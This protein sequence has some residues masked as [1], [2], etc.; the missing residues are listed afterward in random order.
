MEETLVKLNE[1]QF[2]L[3]QEINDPNSSYY[4]VRHL[5][6]PE[7]LYELT[8]VAEWTDRPLPWKDGNWSNCLTIENDGTKFTCDLS[9]KDN[10]GMRDVLM[11][12][13]YYY[14][15][16]NLI[17]HKQEYPALLQKLLEAEL[18]LLTADAREPQRKIVQE[19]KKSQPKK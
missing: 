7:Q 3:V 18:L 1:K 12:L 8:P 14:E 15:M 11:F 4:R 6:G 5:I 9:N 17:L 2:E 13:Y 19:I 10:D 16:K